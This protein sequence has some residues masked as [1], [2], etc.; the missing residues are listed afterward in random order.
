M[1][2]TCCRG[3]EQSES[4]Q[5][6][7]Q[8]NVKFDVHPTCPR[9]QFNETVLFFVRSSTSCLCQHWM[10]WE[11][12]HWG[13]SI[14]LSWLHSKGRVSASMKLEIHQTRLMLESYF[15]V[16]ELGTLIQ[17]TSWC[18]T[19]IFWRVIID[20]CK[21]PKVRFNSCSPYILICIWQ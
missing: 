10:V 2:E 18:V 16:C 5:A 8:A 19:W 13:S 20:Q 15:K 4:K 6:S 9:H 14:Q 17:I 1:M 7:S 3:L 21:W 11:A 12:L